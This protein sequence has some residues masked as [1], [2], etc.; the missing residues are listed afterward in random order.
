MRIVLL[1][2]N[3]N[4]RVTRFHSLC[5]LFYSFEFFVYFSILKKGKGSPYSFTDRRFPELIP[6]IAV[7]LQVM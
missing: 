6:V 5:D 7:G 2:V 3:E 1:D 4:M